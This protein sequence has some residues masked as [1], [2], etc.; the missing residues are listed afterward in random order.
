MEVQGQLESSLTPQVRYTDTAKANLGFQ[1]LMFKNVPMMWD[2]AC[3]GG[4]EGTVSET[5]ASYYGL[6]SK[7]VG[8]KIH[9]DRNF[10]QSGFTDNLTGS[11]G[12]TGASAADALDARVSFITTYG[13][14]VTRNRSRLFKL[15]NVTAA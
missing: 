11:V 2:F 10:K 12:A 9:A 7:Y 3:S 1:N 13:N 8:L 14:Q 5:S 4:T 15:L 6:N